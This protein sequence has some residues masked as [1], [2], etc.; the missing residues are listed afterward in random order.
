[1]ILQWIKKNT[2]I[3]VEYRETIFIRRGSEFGIG[4]WVLQYHKWD[5]F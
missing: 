2:K 1:M 5:E 3:L 4:F